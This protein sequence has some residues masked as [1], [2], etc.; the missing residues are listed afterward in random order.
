[1]QTLKNLNLKLQTAQNGDAEVNQRI[2]RSLVGSLLYLA[3]Q[4]RPD[5]MFTVNILSRHLN[6]PTNQHCVCGKSL[7]R[8]L[9]VSKSLKLTYTKEASSYGLVGESDADWFGEVNDRKSTTGYYFKLNGR[10]A[11]LSWGVKKQ[12]TVALFSSEAEYQGMAAAVQEALYLKQ[13]LEN[14]GIQQKHPIAIGED[15]QSCIK[16]CQNPVMK[17]SKHIETKFQFNRDKREDGT[18]SIH[19]VLTDKMA[20]DIFTIFLPVSKVET[21]RT[22]LMGTDS[23]QSAQ[24]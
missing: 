11:A 19:Y 12:A 15:N 13:L 18:V 5:N 9:R 3:K 17:K 24:V 14:F 20:A 6:A 10:G 21:F 22:V 2:Y 4:A 7:L 16:L 23:T 1:M 8:Y